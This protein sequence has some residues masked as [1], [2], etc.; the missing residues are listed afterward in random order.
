[1]PP[2][3]GVMIATEFHALLDAAV[4]AV[5]VIDES[6]TIITFNRAAERMFGHAAADLQGGDVSVLMGEPYRSRHLQHL[7]RYVE[8][9]DAHI[10]GRSR[11]VEA[12]RAMGTCFRPRSASEKLPTVTSGFLSASYA[13]SEQRAA[14]HSFR[15]LELKLAHVGRF[16][17]DGRDGGWHRTR[18]QSAPLG[19]SDLC[20]GRQAGLAVA[21]R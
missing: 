19:H 14:E 2:D 6:G 13:T 15:A 10:I 4:D 9:G 12:R 7:E 8:S 11:E 5:V 18:D 21:R 16:Q 1:M 20:A 3:K 17:L